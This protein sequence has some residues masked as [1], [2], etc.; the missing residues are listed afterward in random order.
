MLQ[1]PSCPVKNYDLQAVYF[2]FVVWCNLLFEVVNSRPS[3][4][5]RNLLW[6]TRPMQRSDSLG[7]MTQVRVY[8]SMGLCREGFTHGKLD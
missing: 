1:V 5:S 7:W 6:T 3:R 4:C 8:A 2:P